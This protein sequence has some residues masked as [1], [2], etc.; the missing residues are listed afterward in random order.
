MSRPNQDAALAE[1]IR[2]LEQVRGQGIE[3]LATLAAKW[4]G[5]TRW[6][7]GTSNAQMAADIKDEA[8]ASGDDGY[9]DPTACAV[10]SGAVYAMSRWGDDGDA[11]GSSSTPA[12]RGDTGD[13]PTTGAIDAA[14]ELVYWSADELLTLVLYPERIDLTAATR[15]AKLTASIEALHRVQPLVIQARD[16]HDRQCRDHLDLLVYQHLSETALWLREKGD[17]LVHGS[18]RAGQPVPLPGDRPKGCVSCARHVGRDGKAYFQ[19]IDEHNH[20]SRSMCRVCGD[21]TSGEGEMLPLGAVVWMHDT[22]K[23]VTWKVIEEA[24]RAEM[25]S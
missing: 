7:H 8:E 1:A 24:K 22:G 19:P 25:A 10:A 14:L 11:G 9:S 16:R 20:S 6:A 2:D 23:R 21:Y 3:T 15:E 5:H 17:I 18:K 4:F 13:D 12:P